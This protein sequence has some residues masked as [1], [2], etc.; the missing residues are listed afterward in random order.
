MRSANADYLLAG[1]QE[2]YLL[3]FGLHFLYFDLYLKSLSKVFADS[4]ASL[5]SGFM[6]SA[7]YFALPA[8]GCRSYHLGSVASTSRMAPPLKWS[9][10]DQAVC[11]SFY[12]YLDFVA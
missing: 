1:H 11:C 5:C 10:L 9:L 3:H 6:L 2:L 7:K 12:A 4:A 8:S